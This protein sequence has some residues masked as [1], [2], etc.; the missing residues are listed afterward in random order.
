MTLEEL[1]PLSDEEWTHRHIVPYLLDN[2]EKREDETY[3]IKL[4][5]SYDRHKYRDEDGNA[6]KF[7]LFSK[8]VIEPQNWEAH[9]EHVF[10]FL[11]FIKARIHANFGQPNAKVTFYLYTSGATGLLLAWLYAFHGH[12]GNGHKRFETF[13]KPETWKYVSMVFDSV[14]K[15]YY[16]FEDIWG[17]K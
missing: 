3:V 15:T 2:L 1:D 4:G 10:N 16:P 17:G 7:A 11:K 13:K 6:I 5:L 12:K 8:K 14:D 9:Y